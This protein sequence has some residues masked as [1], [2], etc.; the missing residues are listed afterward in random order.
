ML[1]YLF[2]S[3]SS[4]SSVPQ[5]TNHGNAAIQAAPPARPHPAI[6]VSPIA[7]FAN[8]LSSSPSISSFH[9]TDT[10][11]LVVEVVTLLWNE[12]QRLLVD[13]ASLPKTTLFKSLAD[14]CHYGKALAKSHMVPDPDKYNYYEHTYD[15]PSLFSNVI[16][17]YQVRSFLEPSSV[18]VRVFVSSIIPIPSSSSSN[19]SHRT[20]F[21][22]PSTSLMTT[23]ST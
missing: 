1:S 4:S 22:S 2:K 14:A 5:Q 21:Y 13:A 12:Q 16:E 15:N 20:V 17:E 8:L 9:D 11:Y 19:D 3:S 23:C 7:S 10:F 18:V 6:V